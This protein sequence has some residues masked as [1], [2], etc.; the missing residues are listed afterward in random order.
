[1]GDDMVTIFI[2]YLVLFSFLLLMLNK[3]N[4]KIE[5]D[6]SHDYGYCYDPNRDVD[7]ERRLRLQ[8]MTHQKWR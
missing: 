4:K 5:D 3:I 1:M 8:F 7:V 6:C 2:I